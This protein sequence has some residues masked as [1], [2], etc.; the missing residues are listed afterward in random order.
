MHNSCAGRGWQEFKERIGPPTADHWDPPL[1][2]QQSKGQTQEK[3]SLGAK[4]DEPIHLRRITAVELDGG[5]YNLEYLVE[6]ALVKGQPCIIADGRKSLKTSLIID[7]GISLCTGGYFLGKL[8]VNRPCRVGILSGE[9]GMATIQE[10]SRRICNAA[11]FQLSEIVEG[12]A[13]S[14]DIPVFEDLRY[15]DAL[16]NFIVKDQLE[17]IF[18]DPAFMAMSG[19][20]AGNLFIQGKTLRLVNQVCDELGTT[21]C[22][23][24]HTRK[25]PREAPFGPVELDHIAWS[26][27]PEWAR[28]WLLI[29]RREPYEVG[30]GLHKL[31]LST[32]GSAGHNHL[33]AVDIDEGP[34]TTG[35]P[36]KW[37]VTVSNPEDARVSA[38]ADRE[39][40]KDRA[41]AKGHAARV[42][43]GKRRIIEAMVKFP[44][45]ET[46]RRIRIAAGLSPDR[47]DRALGALIQDGTIVPLDLQ[48]SN[49]KTPYDAYKLA[50]DDPR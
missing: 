15:L 38:E 30:S 12:L 8:K 47:F 28:Q 31:W 13:F 25:P 42:E 5:D 45:G 32:G 1:T 41:R 33:W 43:D 36:R 34:F 46:R 2:R 17:V 10:T 7:M 16:R 37:D 49:R 23:V 11:G 35:V 9:S 24:H 48:K 14:P 40:A 26:G 20:D 50:D 19:A 21:F 29:G 44:E 39:A 22:L 18:I 6:G 3:S 4:R 27:F